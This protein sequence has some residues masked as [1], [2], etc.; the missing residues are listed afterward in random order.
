MSEHKL[1]SDFGCRLWSAKPNV[2]NSVGTETPSA[3]NTSNDK[4][5]AAMLGGAALRP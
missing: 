1:A 2:G 4:S 5:L 3:E